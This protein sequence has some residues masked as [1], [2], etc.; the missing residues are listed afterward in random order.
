MMFGN[1]GNT[2]NTQQKNI[3]LA[4]LTVIISFTL[5]LYSIRLFTIQIINGKQYREDTD[6]ISTDYDEIPAQR[7]EIYDRNNNYNQYNQLIN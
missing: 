7:G 4:I 3:K 5:A 6:K 2:D 1:Y